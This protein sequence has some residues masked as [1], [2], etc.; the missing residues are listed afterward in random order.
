[1]DKEGTHCDSIMNFFLTVLNLIRDSIDL[2]YNN[3]EKNDK[4]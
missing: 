2:G 1:M 3:K 4:I